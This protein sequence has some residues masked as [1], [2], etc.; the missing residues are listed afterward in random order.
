MRRR[1]LL[2]SVAAVLGVLAMAAQAH[3][4]TVTPQCSPAPSDCSAA[5]YNQPVDLTWVFD[6]D[7]PDSTDCV[8]ETINETTA[9]G[10]E[11]TCSATWGADTEGGDVTIHVDATDPETT[12][13][14]LSRAPDHGTWFNHTL[15][16]SFT[17]TDATSGVATPCASVD[18]SGPGGSG[19]QVSGACTD[20]AGNTDATPLDSAAFNFD[21]TPPTT[22][23]ATLDRVP[24]Q[25]GWYNHPV[26]VDFTGSDT[27]SGVAP[28]CAS[29][30]YAGPD[31]AAVHASGDCEDNAGNTDPTPFDS[32][33]FQYDGTPPSLAGAN[34]DRPPDSNGWYNHPVSF[35]FQGADATSGLAACS[36]GVAYG[37]PDSA[38]AS[39]AGSC[40]DNAGN[41]ATGS[42]S[43]LYD[44]TPPRVLGA[45]PDRL[46]DRKGWFNHPVRLTFQGIDSTS[47]VASCSRY[48]YSG[49]PNGRT[50]V[51]G[52]C[53]DNAGNSSTA[54]FTM[55]YDATP[56]APAQVVATPGNR[57][58]LIRWTKPADAVLVR[59]VRAR[60]AK[61]SAAKSVIYSGKGTSLVDR[62]LR[63]GT[64]YVYTVTVMDVAGNTTSTSA[65][66]KPTSLSLRP[67]PGA[68]VSL[69]PKLTWKKVRHASYY[70][71]QL[72]LGGTKVLSTW[73][74]TTSYQLKPSW[75]FAGRSYTLVPATYTWYVWP[76]IGPRS[77]NRYGHLLGKSGFTVL[78]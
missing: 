58:V 78:G 7:P 33:D 66:V 2:V 9:A 26:T 50:L 71:V 27:T 43:L 48:T 15:T 40:Q 55:Q 68:V 45:L 28:T 8:P 61:A 39:V 30:T 11:V 74:R 76:G 34:P 72:Y 44:Q 57:K 38:S 14:S 49:A 21:S 41:T 17:G 54:S 31:G 70:N 47:G 3:A 20:A 25:N 56:P 22:T 24:D 51:S 35:A 19:V 1:L 23:G 62:H 73:P 32:P 16:V 52:T 75:L 53:T 46:P 59:V 69:P 65:S 12:D 6:P 67:L 13:S 60:A 4:N 18:Y 42:A 36:S 37:G 63:N 5:W 77:A 29:L 10:Q 64:S